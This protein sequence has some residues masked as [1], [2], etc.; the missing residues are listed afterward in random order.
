MRNTSVRTVYSE[1]VCVL[2][3]ARVC[4]QGHLIGLVCVR[5]C[6]R[7]RVFVPRSKVSRLGGEVIKSCQWQARQVSAL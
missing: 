5:E 7:Q 4:T 2:V 1:L 3:H 6:V